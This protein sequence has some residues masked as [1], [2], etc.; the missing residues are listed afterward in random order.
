MNNKYDGYIYQNISNIISEDGFY[1]VIVHV[2][3]S[4]SCIY[5]MENYTLSSQQEPKR[6]SYVDCG[7]GWDDNGD[8]NFY[9]N[10]YTEDPDFVNPVSPDSSVTPPDS[11]S[12][13]QIII[14]AIV[15]FFKN[16][17]SYIWNF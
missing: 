10:L 13:F 8:N 2:A 15:N 3:D 17:F 5:P 6:Q 4:S 1:A 14:E 16:I 9:L 12:W 7:A 11:E